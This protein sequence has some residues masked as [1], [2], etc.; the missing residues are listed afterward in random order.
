MCEPTWTCIYYGSALYYIAVFVWYQKEKEIAKEL[1][2]YPGLHEYFDGWENKPR[3][4][5]QRKELEK[6]RQ[7]EYKK[8][9]RKK[10]KNE[11]RSRRQNR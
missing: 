5:R 10:V 1:Q 6:I 3:A 2:K 11:I 4:I 9:M 7:R 8:D